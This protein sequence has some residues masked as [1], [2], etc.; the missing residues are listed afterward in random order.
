MDVVL[1]SRF[2]GRAP[3][4]SLGRRMVLILAVHFTRLTTRL[5]VSD[6][7]NGLRAF[8]AEVA[9]KLRLN[10]LRM[11]HA[12]EFLELI[13]AAGLS[14]TEAPTT[15]TYSDY[16]RAK[17]QSVLGA[18]DIVYELFIRRLFR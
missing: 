5:N 4:I 18:V 17:G 15:I 12:S 14:Y 7:H 3:G 1:G 8:R 9:G 16:S 10:Q 6:A 13:K 11:A 2:L